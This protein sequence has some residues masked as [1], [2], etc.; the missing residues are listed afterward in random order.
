[1]V[2]RRR[3]SELSPVFSPRPAHTIVLGRENLHDHKVGTGTARFMKTE[4]DKEV[5]TVASTFHAW[6]S[7]ETEV[8]EYST[9]H[10][11]TFSSARCLLYSIR[12]RTSLQ[13]GDP[14]SVFAAVIWNENLLASLA[15]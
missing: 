4:R 6:I 12:Y 7:P 8:E 13:A 1:M 11:T 15:G 3:R 14:R 9:V 2:Q 10:Q 5:V